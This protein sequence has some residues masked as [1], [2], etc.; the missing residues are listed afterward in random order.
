MDCLALRVIENVHNAVIVLI[1]APEPGGESELR[2]I[3][4][5]AHFANTIHF[6]R[7]RCLDPFH[8]ACDPFTIA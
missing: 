7:I 4:A 2:A 8:A 3:Q 1:L 5:T 6:R